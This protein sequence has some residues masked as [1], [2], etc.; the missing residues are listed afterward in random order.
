MKQYTALFLLLLCSFNLPAEDKRQLLTANSPPFLYAIGKVSV[1]SE[2]ILD[3]DKAH[4][5]ENCS[6]TLVNIGKKQRVISAWHCIEHYEN[7]GKAITFTIIDKNNIRQTRRL[8]IIDSGDSMAEDWLI[9]GLEEPIQ[10]PHSVDLLHDNA[11]AEFIAA[12]FSGD[13]LIGNH[14]ERLTYETNCTPSLASISP[15]Q[16]TLDCYAYKGASGGAIFSHDKLAGVI[17][18][19]DNVGRIS[20]VPVQRFIDV[21]KKTF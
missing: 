14:G 4:F 13:D 6:G 3:D 21:L 10:M 1:P 2:K 12:G 20:F 9:L 5:I 17:S 11:E 19:G 8:F 16:I 7:F 15:H 18:Q